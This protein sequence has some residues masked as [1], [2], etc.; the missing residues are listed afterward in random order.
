MVREIGKGVF[1]QRECT[2]DFRDVDAKRHGDGGLSRVARGRR[3]YAG[4]C[5]AARCDDGEGAT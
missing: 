4:E 1:D 2:C 3:V 5:A